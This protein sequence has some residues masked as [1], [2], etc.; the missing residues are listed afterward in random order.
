[1][2]DKIFKIKKISP[3][4]IEQLANFF[5]K[6]YGEQSI[7]QSKQFLNW[8]F[9]SIQENE[10]Y[11]PGCLIGVN[12]HNEIVSHYGGLKYHLVLEGKIYPITWGVNAFTFPEWR[13]MGI[14]SEI[15]AHL[16]KENKINGVIG[17]T[18]K[19]ANFYNSIDYNIFNYQRFKRFCKILDVNK[20]KDVI[21]YIGQNP[22]QIHAS[23]LKTNPEKINN[24]SI[25]CLNGKNIDNFSL[26]FQVNVKVTT[27]RTK[28]FLK[29]RFF[30]NPVIH[31]DSFACTRG[32]KISSYI[33]CR[34]EQLEPLDHSVL[35]I[36]DV[37]GNPDEIIQLIQKV[38]S[39]SLEKKI[40][41]MDFSVFG[42]LYD[43]VFT[44]CGFSELKED[45]YAI[46]PQTCSPVTSRENLEYIGLQSESLKHLLA[47]LKVDDVYFT[48]MDSDRDRAARISQLKTEK[49]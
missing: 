36:I 12:K 4:D 6:A 45:D 21:K 22:E 1:M 38:I 2:E 11:M 33:V 3:T 34:E 5:L 13:G 19:T 42:N 46:L 44:E 26:D 28:E 27:H 20:T 40:I 8:Y 14:N 32:K 18:K 29:W 49:S 30:H 43:E 16:K 15:I 25:T 7:F 48:R 10:V 41:Y 23:N 47:T 17:F 9:N 37:F 31:Y 24:Q 35:R 39:E